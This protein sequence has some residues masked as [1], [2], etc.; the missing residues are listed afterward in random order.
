MGANAQSLEAIMST[1]SAE[2]LK[3]LTIHV[4][5]KALDLSRDYMLKIIADKGEEEFN[6]KFHDGTYS[7]EVKRLSA[8]T[9]EDHILQWLKDHD[10]VAKD[11]VPYLEIEDEPPPLH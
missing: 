5:E 10:I 9:T 8:T 3:E 6:R 7:A 2:Q 11:F 1:L 4:V